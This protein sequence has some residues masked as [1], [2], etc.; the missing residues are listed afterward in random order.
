VVHWTAW[1]QRQQAALDARLQ[2]AET[3]LA[4]MQIRD[5]SQS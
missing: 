1:S 3:E 5:N 2:R 4:R